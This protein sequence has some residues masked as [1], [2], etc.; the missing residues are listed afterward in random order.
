MREHL[1]RAQ[2]DVPAPIDEVFAFFADATNLARITPSKLAFRVLTP[3]PIEMRVGTIIDYRL[4]VR[5]IPVRWRTRIAAWEPGRRFVDEQLKGPYRRW[6]HQHSFEAI[7]GG[8]RMTDEV[9]YIVPMGWIVHAWLV[10]PD[11]ERIFAYREQ[12]IRE[13]FKRPA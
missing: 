13:H 8:T 3:S 1:F 9:R 10:R 11:I 5:G 7:G 2:T 6:I 4:R 12:V